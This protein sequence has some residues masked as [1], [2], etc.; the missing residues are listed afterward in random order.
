MGKGLGL[1]NIF[2]TNGC[3]KR[4]NLSQSE[5]SVAVSKYNQLETI[6]SKSSLLANL[7]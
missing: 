7:K 3:K 1:S 5:T 4:L 2:F 6:T